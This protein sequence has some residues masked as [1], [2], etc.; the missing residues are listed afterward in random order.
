M[1][2][3]GDFFIQTTRD[4]TKN[5]LLFEIGREVMSNSTLNKI[6]KK[7]EN[8]YWYYFNLF[9]PLIEEKTK[10]VLSGVGNIVLFYNFQK[11]W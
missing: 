2:L 6:Y 3:K 5:T 9:K 11:L 4:I 1:Q 7:F 8:R 10:I